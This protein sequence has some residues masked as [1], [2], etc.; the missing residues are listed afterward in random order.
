MGFCPFFMIAF[1]CW[2][3]EFGLMLAF[4][5]SRNP[6]GC[7]GSWWGR[8]QV[9]AMVE[10]SAEGELLCSMQVACWLSQER[11]QYVLLGLHEWSSL[12]SLSGLSQGSSCYSGLIFLR[13]LCFFFYFWILGFNLSCQIIIP[14]FGSDFLD[15]WGTGD[16][17]LLSSS[18]ITV[19]S[20][21]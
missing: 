1:L 15:E 16:P 18:V 3:I 2:F 13:F 6:T 8:Q 10:T 14:R 21:F 11:M 19:S 9:A 17:L 7:W 12:F 4:L 20:L 5:F